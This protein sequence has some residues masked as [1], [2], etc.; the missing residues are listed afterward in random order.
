MLHDGKSS[1]LQRGG[2]EV[3]SEVILQ[4]IRDVDRSEGVGDSGVWLVLD[5]QHLE[6]DHG[7]NFVEVSN[8]G[9]DA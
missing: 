3:L 4:G 1:G 7:P 2:A 9:H 6:G 8:E 5:L